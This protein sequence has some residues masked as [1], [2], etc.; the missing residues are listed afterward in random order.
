M[1]PGAVVTAAPLNPPF[2]GKALQLSSR[3]PLP[4]RRPGADS[5]VSTSS[6]CAGNGSLRELFAIRAPSLAAAAA[7]LLSSRERA[8]RS[9]G[10]PGQGWHPRRGGLLPS[11]SPLP[12]V[13]VQS[14]PQLISAGA[15]GQEQGREPWLG[16]RLVDLACESIPQR[17]A[18]WREQRR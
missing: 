2:V 8:A 3:P 15:G 1:L 5:P 12:P 9:F 13:S 4:P 14:L 17:A 10:C 18:A 7:E 11:P 6:F 16:A